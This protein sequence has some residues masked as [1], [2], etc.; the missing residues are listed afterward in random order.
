[1]AGVSFF[2]KFAMTKTES[3]YLKT[4]RC[5]CGALAVT[6]TAP[7]HA[8]QACSCQDCQCRTGSTFSYSA[9]F[10]ASD[11]AIRGEFR[12]WRRSSQSG[13][14]QE[15]NFCPTCGVT[16]FVRLEVIPD[17]I[18]I[19][20]GSFTDPDFA[21]PDKLYWTSKSHRW[22]QLTAGIERIETQ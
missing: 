1:L 21:P 9:F 3:T 7:Q 6:V 20:V 15:S 18:G 10:A 19:S 5:A 13:R 16:V 12:C 17:L 4:A 2:P 8:V 11:V 22:L 14:W